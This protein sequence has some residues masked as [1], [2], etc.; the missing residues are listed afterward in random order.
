MNIQYKPINFSLLEQIQAYSLTLNP[1]A[2][3]H[4]FLMDILSKRLNSLEEVKIILVDL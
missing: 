3:I 1:Q 4:P 2:A